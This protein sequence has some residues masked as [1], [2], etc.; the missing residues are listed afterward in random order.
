M[1]ANFFH[2]ISLLRKTMPSQSS[3][4]KK[5]KTQKKA[6]T[7]DRAPAPQPRTYNQKFGSSSKNDVDSCLL[8]VALGSSCLYLAAMELE[9]HPGTTDDNE[10]QRM[11][12]YI[13][14]GRKKIKQKRFWMGLL[15][16][17]VT[18]VFKNKAT[19]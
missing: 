15:C 2:E 18:D 12:C 6:K 16:K 4:G 5:T 11:R 1:K 10:L 3:V 13:L 19:E 9:E 7:Q 14:D 17:V 8:K